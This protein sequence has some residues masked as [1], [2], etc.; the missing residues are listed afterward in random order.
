MNENLSISMCPNAYIVMGMH[1]KDYEMSILNRLGFIIRNYNP[2]P[3]ESKIYPEKV[4]EIAEKSEETIFCALWPEPALYGWLEVR[5]QHTQ[6]YDENYLKEYLS[7][8]G[9]Y[10]P[11]LDEKT[12]SG[13]ICRE[14]VKLSDLIKKLIPLKD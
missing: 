14:L 10:P 6:W 4:Y 7:S 1:F 5:L 12:V 13:D 3:Q 9:I 8:I 2:L 11:C